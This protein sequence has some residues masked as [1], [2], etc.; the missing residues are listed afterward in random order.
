M[1]RTRS[2]YDLLF[3]ISSSRKF[4]FQKMRTKNPMSLS[5]PFQNPLPEVHVSAFFCSNISSF[6]DHVFSKLPLQLNM[7]PPAAVFLLKSTSSQKKIIAAMDVCR[8]LLSKY[9]LRLRISLC[10]FLSL[11][12]ERT[13]SSE[14]I[15]PIMMFGVF[16]WAKY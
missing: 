7:S 4:I 5:R 16:F 6:P 9:Q 3:P 14:C 8:L 10:V 2:C 12:Y 15:T 13:R 11:S 1:R